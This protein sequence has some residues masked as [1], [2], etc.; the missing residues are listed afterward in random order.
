M[1]FSPNKDI[2]FMSLQFIFCL[3]FVCL[4]G[5]EMGEWF[6]RA[7]Y[8]DDCHFKCA[9]FW[10]K[11]NEECDATCAENDGGRALPT[12]A[13]CFDYCVCQRDCGFLI[14]HF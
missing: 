5:A 2:S 10:P 3:T 11:P 13:E 7:Y 12:D 8:G 6:D 4:V 14:M 1:H 9:I